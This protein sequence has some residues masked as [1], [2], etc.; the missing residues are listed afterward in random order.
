MKSPYL[1]IL[2]LI[3]A[4]SP[5][6]NLE[7]QG[8]NY[9]GQEAPGDAPEIFGKEVIS[10]KD[11]FDMGFTMS[12]DGKS[13]A[14]GVAHESDPAETAI[15]LMHFVDGEWTT[16]SKDFLHDNI[17]TL[18]PM[19]DPTGSKLYFAK[20]ANGALTDLWV[21]DYS[22]N[23]ATDPQPLDSIFNSDSREAGHGVSENG[24]FYFTSNRDDQ[25]QCCGD[26]YYSE[27]GSEGYTTVQKVAELSSVEDEESLFLSPEGDYIII[28][29]WRNELESKHDL[30]ISFKTKAGYWT[31]LQRLNSRIN[32]QEIEQRPFVS[33]DRKYLFFSRTSVTQVDGQDTYEAD[34]YWVSTKSIFKPYLYNG[35]IDIQIEYDKPFQLDLPEDLFQDVDDTSLFYQVSLTDG[36][37]L[38]EWIRFDADNLSLSGTWKSKEPLTIKIMATDSAGNSGDFRFQINS[39]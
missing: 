2:V 21:A 26:V 23:K 16:P 17:N 18:F 24:S 19:F 34:I 32:S 10:V 33:P 1:V 20:S 4:C 25:Y 30:Y 37:Q 31:T 7:D 13:I 3:I 28:Q 22:S 9:L 36:A 12:P 5:R 15:Y 39:I 6:Q 38:P 29:A 27:F 11:R 35:D 14:F 8:I